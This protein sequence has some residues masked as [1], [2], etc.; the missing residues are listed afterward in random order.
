M[1]KIM[2]N[3]SLTSCTLPSVKQRSLDPEMNPP[4]GNSTIHRDPKPYIHQIR[5]PLA[6]HCT[7]PITE[8]I[9]RSIIFLSKLC[10]SRILLNNKKE[11]KKE[12]RCLPMLV[13]KNN[14]K[15]QSAWTNKY[16]YKGATET[17]TWKQVS[18]WI[19]CSLR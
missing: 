4:F 16:A 12:P 5:I 18:I 19:S 2:R 6:Y 15:Q 1:A 9:S 17:G 7:N 14:T 8:N 13:S 11:K 3:S 10:S